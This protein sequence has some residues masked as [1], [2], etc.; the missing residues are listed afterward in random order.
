MA[1]RSLVSIKRYYELRKKYMR[2]SSEFCLYFTELSLV[3]RIIGLVLNIWEN[4]FISKKVTL[5]PES[6]HNNKWYVVN[7]RS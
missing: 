3:N 5:C 7:G 4:Q 1:F 2:I 6:S